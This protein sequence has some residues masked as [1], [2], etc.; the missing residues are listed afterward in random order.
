[1]SLFGA[2]GYFHTMYKKLYKEAINEVPEGQ[3]RDIIHR[4]MEA[5]DP[6]LANQV[7]V[8]V[9]NLNETLAERTFMR[10]VCN[11]SFVHC[12]FFVQIHHYFP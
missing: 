6:F 7:R 8:K 10:W 1:M 2:G 9:G 5:Q 11:F 12:I 3:T 4:N